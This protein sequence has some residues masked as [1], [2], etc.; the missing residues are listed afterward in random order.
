[1]KL[2]IAG[3][4]TGGHLFPGLAVAD[5]LKKQDRSAKVLFVGTERGIEA[6]VV[7]ARGYRLE[8]IEVS[9]YFGKGVLDKL[10][11]IP[12]VIDAVIASIRILKAFAPDVVLGVGGYASGPVVLAARLLKIPT[13][14]HE[15]NAAPG[16]TNRLLSKL[17]DRVCISF[18]RSVDHFPPQKTVLTGNPVRMECFS[19]PAPKKR[20]HLLVFGG[21]RGAQAINSAMVEALPHL[22]PLRGKLTITHQSGEEDY[23]RMWVGY[24]SAGWR[25]AV[26][27]V[28]FIERMEEAYA[29]APLVVCR[30][31]ATTLAEL[32][33]CGRGSILVP[34]PYAAEDHQTVNATEMA[35]GGGA[36]LL[37][38]TELTGKSLASRILHLMSRPEELMQM[39]EKVRRLAKPAATLLMVEEIRSLAE[40]KNDVRKD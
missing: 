23:D 25:D 35:E 26:Q 31:G 2:V 6:R 16:L 24:E 36:I 11:L 8:L 21:S 1:M 13:I 4:G 9:G 10:L 19:V 39:G 27:I 7:P 29:E 12:K 5:L 17:V 30:A 18:G 34:Y 32:S 38:Q 33:A 40:G 22:E 37:P 15:Q 3:G 14:I 28:P 20:F